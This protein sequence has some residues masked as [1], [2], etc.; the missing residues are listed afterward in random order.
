M[1]EYS[2][3]VTVQKDENGNEIR[4]KESPEYYCFKH[5]MDPAQFPV[6]PAE[7]WD[8]NFGWTSV[9]SLAGLT[10]GD[11]KVAL[12]N[13]RLRL[14]TIFPDGHVPNDTDIVISQNPAPGDRLQDGFLVNVT[15]E[16]APPVVVTPGS[17]NN[18][19]NNGNANNNGNV[20]NGQKISLQTLSP[21][22]QNPLTIYT[23]DGS[24]SRA[25]LTYPYNGFNVLYS[26]LRSIVA[27]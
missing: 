1:R 19:G 11:A 2:T 24:V 9:P 10:L 7:T 6:N 23:Q 18:P 22:T 15:V 20:G 5:N 27:S 12:A 4:T 17:V 25:V 26:A 13:A 21:Q 16:P 14:G 3:S 8:S